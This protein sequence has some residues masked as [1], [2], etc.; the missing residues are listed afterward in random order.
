[1]NNSKL[2][3]IVIPTFNRYAEL[4]ETLTCLINQ[5]KLYGLYKTVSFIIADNASD[6]N[7]PESLN[8]IIFSNN[9]QYFK[10]NTNIGITKNILK[11]FGL[12]NSKYVW[13]FGDDDFIDNSLLPKL[14]DYL[15][16]NVD[17]IQVNRQSFSDK[18]KIKYQNT[19]ED[20]LANSIELTKQSLFDFDRDS[21]FITSNI[22]KTIVFQKAVDIVQSNSN[23]EIL[24]NNYFIKA[25][26]FISILNSE[27]LIRIDSKLIFQRVTVG[28]HFHQ[29]PELIFKTFFEDQFEIF[30]ILKNYN[31]IFSSLNKEYQYY[32][33]TNILVLRL[34]HSNSKE[35]G[36]KILNMYNHPNIITFLLCVCPKT[37][38]LKVYKFYKLI[39]QTP[40]PVHFE[41][42]S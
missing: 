8:E 3:N 21:G 30:N 4:E 39:K 19:N 7:L 9:I 10:N 13:F 6:S 36:K 16:Q 28:S 24:S 14:S 42:F 25:A 22:C 31:P 12:V 29:T 37:I 26:N 34:F 15:K 17:Y 23:P 1:M 5:V 27:Q 20:I 33:L 11:A 38:L 32:S 18:N 35:I 40:Y 41:K 2:L